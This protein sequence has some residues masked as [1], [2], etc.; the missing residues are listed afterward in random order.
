M[1]SEHDRLV[2]GRDSNCDSQAAKTTDHVGTES[3]LTLTNLWATLLASES[4][5]NTKPNRDIEIPTAENQSSLI[6]QQLVKKGGYSL[7]RQVG[8][9]MIPSGY[10][11][12]VS[13]AEM[14]SCTEQATIAYCDQHAEN[15]C[16]ETVIFGPGL[17]PTGY[18][19]SIICLKDCSKK[20][21]IN[22]VEYEPKM[23]L[24]KFSETHYLRPKELV[25]SY[26]AVVNHK[27]D[28]TRKWYKATM[29]MKP[30]IF[31]SNVSTN[32]NS[33]NGDITTSEL[34]VSN[35][36]DKNGN[37]YQNG[38]LTEINNNVN[39]INQQISLRSGPFIYNV[40]SRDEGEEVLVNGTYQHHNGYH[41]MNGY[42]E[43][44]VNMNG[45]PKDN[46]YSDM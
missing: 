2:C 15:R 44:M 36:D 27:T 21:F 42:A 5:S 38:D 35:G 37:V 1:L 32:V 23:K 33:D 8:S 4:H 39:E 29:E 43:D 34:I 20:R 24:R 16:R 26:A 12:C 9:I 30:K 40:P 3:T 13:V 14:P 11:E 7:N 10:S 17:A 22:R 6:C 41:T 19:S 18:R 46:W 31:T 28:Q 25:R 45:Y